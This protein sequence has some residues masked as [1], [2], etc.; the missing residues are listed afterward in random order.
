[1]QHASDAK[2][3][4][5]NYTTKFLQLTARAAVRDTE[6]SVVYSADRSKMAI[7]LKSESLEISLCLGAGLCVLRLLCCYCL[8][9]VGLYSFVPR[10]VSAQYFHQTQK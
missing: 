1:M 3:Y 6:R 9:S 10:E 8:Y 4:P 2:M 5:H 7:W